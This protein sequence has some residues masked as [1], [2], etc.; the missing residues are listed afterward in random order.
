MEFMTSGP[1]HMYRSVGVSLLLAAI[2][3]P[4]APAQQTTSPSSPPSPSDHLARP[5]G[6]D[7]KLADWAEVSSY[8]RK[9]AETTPTVRLTTLGKT[10]EGRDLLLAIIS[11]PENLARLDQLKAHAKTLADPRGKSEPEKA[12][13]LRDG[14]VFLVVTPSMHSTEVGATEMGMQFAYQLATSDEEPFKSARE[15]A[16]IFITPTLN[17]D[18]LDVVVSHY[19]SV[20]GTSLEASSLGR[21]YQYYTGHDNNRDWFMM[22]QAETRALSKFLY[23]ECFPQ[24]LWDVH[25]QG[26]GRERFFTPPYRDPLNPNIDPAVVAG[27]N[28]IGTRAVLDMTA[29]GFTG[30]ATGSTYDMWWH[31][32]NRSTPARHN[33]IGILTEAASAQ[34]ASPIFQNRSELK[35]STGEVPYGPSVNMISPWEGGWWRIGDII[36]YELAF[37][38][39]LLATINREPMLWK[40]TML[41]AAERA[42]ASNPQGVKYWIVPA[43]NRDP[44]AVTRLMDALLLAG[45]EIHTTPDPITAH[46]RQF[47]AGSIII[48][49]D[50]PFGAHV[51]DLFEV[52][53]YPEGKAPYDS[54]GWT[55][56]LLMGVQRVEVAEGLSPSTRLVRVATAAEATGSIRGQLRLQQDE[57]DLANSSSWG[58]LAKRLTAGETLTISADG[59]KVSPGKETREAG[60]T[61]LSKMPRIGVYSPHTGV[62]SEGWLRYVLDLHHV[63]FTTV[64]NEALRSGNLATDFDVII[65][66]D[67]SE[68]T[69]TRGRVAGS[70]PESLTGGLSPEGTLALQSFVAEGG[71]LIAIG[72]AS[73]Y[74]IKTFGLPL[75]SALTGEE[76]KGFSCPGSV[77]RARTETHPLTAGLPLDVALFFSGDIAFVPVKSDKATGSA[78]GK[79]LATL[80][81]YSS[82]E[83]LL[84]GYIAKPSV[85][86]DKAAWVRA[87]VGAGKVHLFGFSPHYRAWTQGTIPLL[88]RAVFLDPP[89]T[90]EK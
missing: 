4:P 58:E 51:K 62:M 5:V 22:T 43:D 75:A 21:L 87:E 38:R 16:V 77:L 10:T 2:W 23:T 32:G 80:L 76:A 41:A 74:A 6:T 59:R 17:P 12:T 11:S 71:N 89:S 3:L 67:M 83:L 24:I 60:K 54:A 19:R 78:A 25:Q 90:G 66:A 52:Q 34:L 29:E 42:V 13:A 33:V 50:Q 88:M 57:L 14:K 48:R 8:Y 20:V 81:T 47:P 15:N 9:L 30:I 85:I 37:G 39:S 55:L 46:G 73:N 35:S 45:V 56:P 18:G 27:I 63:P 72:A 31:G 68:T 1:V 65:M 86:E 26:N 69:L 44:A 79:K 53:R 70:A 64:K 49:R 36:N 28:L 7:F 40:R 84:S 61:T 82:S